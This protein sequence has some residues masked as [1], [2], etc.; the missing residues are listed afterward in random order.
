MRKSTP[1]AART[2]ATLREVIAEGI[3]RLEEQQDF[4]A[5]LEAYERW[6]D[7][8]ERDHDD[9]RCGIGAVASDAPLMPR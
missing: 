5:L 9:C 7:C 1:R 3:A 8:D 4:L 2:A 6:S